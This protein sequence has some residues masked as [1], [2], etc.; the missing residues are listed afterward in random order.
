MP[1]LYDLMVR[2]SDEDVRRE[3]LKQVEIIMKDDPN[4]SDRVKA[5]LQTIRTTAERSSP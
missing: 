2:M 1:K 3:Y 4:V 5:S